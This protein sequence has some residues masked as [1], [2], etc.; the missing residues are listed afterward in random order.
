MDAA[1]PDDA[2]IQRDYMSLLS[3]KS[4]MAKYTTSPFFQNQL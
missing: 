3:G 1:L 4:W 2:D